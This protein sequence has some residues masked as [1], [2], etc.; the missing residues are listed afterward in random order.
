[1]AAQQMRCSPHRWCSGNPFDSPL[2]AARRLLLNL[3]IKGHCSGLRARRVHSNISCPRNLSS[4]EEILRALVLRC[5][6]G[7]HHSGRVWTIRCPLLPHGNSSSNSSRCPRRSGGQLDPRRL[8]EA[9]PRNPLCRGRSNSVALNCSRHSRNDPC[10]S[11]SSSSSSSRSRLHLNQWPRLYLWPRHTGYFPP[12]TSSR[13]RARPNSCSPR[14][15]PGPPAPPLRLH[16]RC[17]LRL[18][19]PL[20]PQLFLLVAM[21][22]PCL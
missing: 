20:F 12:R 10:F 21:V 22:P 1:M 17:P 7:R 19:A 13:D 11:S 3:V 18:R 4:R 2:L 9:R 15:A 6:P 14:C 16:P 5:S 8:Q